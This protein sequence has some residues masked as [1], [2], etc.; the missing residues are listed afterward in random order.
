MIKKASTSAT[1]L[2][3]RK[4][5]QS[6]IEVQQWNRLPSAAGVKNWTRWKML[7]KITS[8]GAFFIFK[9]E[10]YVFLWWMRARIP[11]T[12]EVT[13]IH[14]CIRLYSTMEKNRVKELHCCHCSGHKIGS[15][16]LIIRPTNIFFI[17]NIGKF[18][19]GFNLKIQTSTSHM[20]I[21]IIKFTYFFKNSAW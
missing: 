2:S 6:P 3:Q 16:V 19:R 18:T 8:T 7:T 20:S 5:S 1:L 15:T 13:Q 10:T 11:T 14:A 12:T 4:A 9:G 17:V 21:K